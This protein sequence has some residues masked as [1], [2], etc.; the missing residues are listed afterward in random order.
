MTT[1][2]WKEIS[3]EKKPEFINIVRVLNRYYEANSPRDTENNSNRFRRKLEEAPQD[4]V[5][6][7]LKKFGE[8]EFLVHVEMKNGRPKKSETDT[9]IHIDGIQEERDSLKK[10]G[11]EDHPVYH[12]I[13]LTDIFESGSVASKRKNLPK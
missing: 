9:W 8:Y 10:K 3:P 5:R 4:S 12:I 7:F 6:V 2:I 11:I 13:G 1:T